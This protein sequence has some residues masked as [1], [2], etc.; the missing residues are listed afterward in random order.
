VE[1]IVRLKM[2]PD[3]ADVI[4]PATEIF[5]KIMDFAEIQEMIVPKIGLS[6]GIILELFEDWKSLREVNV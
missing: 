2:K 6:D 1:R 3:R 5:S 4:L